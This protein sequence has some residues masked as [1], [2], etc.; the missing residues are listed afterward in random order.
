[1][2]PDDVSHTV[3]DRHYT[4]AHTQH[5]HW[6]QEYRFECADGSWSL[7]F[8]RGYIIRNATGQAV[9]MIGAMQDITAR[10]A[11]EEKHQRM[12]QELFKQNAD[13]QQFTYIVSH[14]LRTRWQMPAGTPP[15]SSVRGRTLLYSTS[16]WRIC[17]P[18]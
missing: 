2:H 4:I 17:K 7:V 6:Q 12:A 11:A 14:N 3:D 15:C 5:N 10:K 9:R 16:R 13:L 1:V 8:D 18:V